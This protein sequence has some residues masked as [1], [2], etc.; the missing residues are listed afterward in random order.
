MHFLYLWLIGSFAPTG[1]IR[2]GSNL[3]DTDKPDDGIFSET[4]DTDVAHTASVNHRWTPPPDVL[5][6]MAQH[7]QALLER[8]IIWK[9]TGNT[10]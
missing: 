1:L 9:M 3:W 2:I 4:P 5:A 6:L 8:V 7:N 10:P